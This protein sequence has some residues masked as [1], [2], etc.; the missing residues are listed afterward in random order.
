MNVSDELGVTVPCG[1]LKD[2][3]KVPPSL[4]VNVKVFVEDP[5]SENPVIVLSYALL[6]SAELPPLQVTAPL[7]VKAF[8]LP[9]N[10]NP[11]SLVI[12]VYPFQYATLPDEPLPVTL[13]TCVLSIF[14]QASVA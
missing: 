8:V 4:C 10:V 7:T 6:D 5:L 1:T 3:V 2:V 14:C 13:P 11:A 9:L 12:L